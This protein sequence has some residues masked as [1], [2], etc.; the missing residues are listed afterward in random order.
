MISGARSRFSVHLSE[1][2][3]PLKHQCKECD[4]AREKYGHRFMGGAT[5]HRLDCVRSPCADT[6]RLR[7]FLV[8]IAGLEF[9][10]SR[11]PR[12]LIC[13]FGLGFGDGFASGFF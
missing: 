11:D 4:K 12:S 5:V 2:S 1:G 6:N 7:S 8:P 3:I 9:G 13:N 10:L